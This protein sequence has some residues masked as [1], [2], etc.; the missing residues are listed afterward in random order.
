MAAI[1]KSLGKY[2][3]LFICGSPLE[4]KALKKVLY[5]LTNQSLPILDNWPPTDNYMLIVVGKE[6]MKFWLGKSRR[7]PIPCRRIILL[8]FEY[9]I[10][11][12]HTHLSD[13]LS[14]ANAG[15]AIVAI[16]SAIK[17]PPVD[18]T[19]L[20]E[21]VAVLSDINWHQFPNRVQDL[22]STAKGKGILP[23]V[24]EWNFLKELNQLLAQSNMN[25]IRRLIASMT[26]TNRLKSF[27]EL[28]FTSKSK[29]VISSVISIY[30]RLES[31]QSVD[32]VSKILET[33]WPACLELKSAGQFS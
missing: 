14:F 29:E 2:N 28:I 15:N 13:D 17:D 7:C 24:R 5:L 32:N 9:D 31:G 33:H 21:L 25:D 1:G 18:H 8:P 10:D 4:S 27:I 6:E 19:R 26:L 16:I 12:M 23:P 30:D 11:G 22:V 20:H 3:S